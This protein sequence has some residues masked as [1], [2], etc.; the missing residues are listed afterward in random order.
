MANTDASAVLSNLEARASDGTG[1]NSENP[2][3]GT[4][5]GLYSRAT[6]PSYGTPD[7]YDWQGYDLPYTS[8]I[9]NIF[10]AQPEGETVKN[11]YGTNEHHQF[12]G[13]FIAHDIS[14]ARPGTPGVNE[15]LPVD[16][17]FPLTRDAYELDEYGVRQ[18]VTKTT[19]YIDLSAVYGKSEE[20]LN[21][22]REVDSAKLLMNTVDNRLPTILEVAAVH[23]ADPAELTPLFA[24]LPVPPTFPATGDER[25]FQSP[26]L[27]SIQTIWARNHNWHVDQL[28]E[29]HPDWTTEQV[30]QAARALNEAEFQH[31]IYSEYVTELFGE[32]SLGAYAGYSANVDPS[33]INEFTTVS[34]R[35]GHDQASESLD[36]IDESGNV[37]FNKTLAESVALGPAALSDN[38][39]LDAWVRGQLSQSSQEID[40]KMVSS[41]GKVPIL[42]GIELDLRALDV[43]R[44][45]EHGVGNYNALREGL[46]LAVYASFD[47][48]AAANNVDAASLEILKSLYG[49]DI[50]KLDSIIGGLLEK[51]AAGSQLGETFTILGVM[52]YENLRTGDR[53]FYEERFKDSPELLEMI[54]STSYADIIARNTDIDYVYHDAFAAHDRIGGTD[55]RDY[56]KGGKGADLII[57]FE[58][59]DKLYGRRGDDD[60]YGGE[61]RDKLYGQSGDDNLFGE[62]GNDRLYGGGGDD[63][64]SGGEGHDRLY[65][66][67]GED[68]LNGGSGNDKLKGGH[69]AD[70]FVFEEGSGV[71]TIYDFNTRSGDQIDLSD[72]GFESFSEVKAA[73]SSYWWFN[74][75]IDLGDGNK[76]IVKHNWKGRF[77]E[78]DFIYA[79]NFGGSDVD[80]IG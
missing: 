15:V 49:D 32:D 21:L 35:F 31:V 30:F 37:L 66:S 47:E 56:L 61:G 12:F 72:Y 10:L 9:S 25:A 11:S 24:A 26:Q 42:P 34:N 59:N 50:S 67:W 17:P 46:G 19:S 36:V 41:A 54:K 53:F 4:A 14:Q 74:T 63:Y 13:Q 5:D 1:N 29:K 57:G 68:T 23:G 55:G 51:D 45:R 38:E 65:G 77:S 75:K 8:D 3:W 76:V 79:E 69:G 48:F 60:L 22:L 58:G 18:T 73:M 43:L 27:L 16:L 80:V 62:E 52:Q 20:V 71:D 6:T 78:D 7:G 64:L 44:G 40:G 28:E 70:I 33:V 2:R 39:A